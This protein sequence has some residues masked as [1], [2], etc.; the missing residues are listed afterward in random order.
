MIITN[1]KIENT[2]KISINFNYSFFLIFKMHILTF[3]KP[4]LTKKMSLYCS[5]LK[6]DAIVLNS[7]LRQRF[8]PTIYPFDILCLSIS[9]FLFLNILIG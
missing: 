4:V 9:T 8:I 3:K 7:H 6:E 2:L 5:I 1:S